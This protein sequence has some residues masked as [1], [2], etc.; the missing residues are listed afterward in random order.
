MVIRASMVARASTPDERRMR[1][2]LSLDSEDP[3]PHV[4]SLAGAIGIGIGRRASG[5]LDGERRVADLPVSALP[6]DRHAA[7]SIILVPAVAQ[8]HDRPA[9]GLEALGCRLVADAEQVDLIVS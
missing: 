5:L 7:A 2:G 9:V 4:Q 1:H 8:Q 6:P 3:A